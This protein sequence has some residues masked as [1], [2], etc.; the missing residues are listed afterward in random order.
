MFSRIKMWIFIVS[1]GIIEKVL[2]SFALSLFIPAFSSSSIEGREAGRSGKA[3][4][5]SSVSL[6]LISL[7]KVVDNDKAA[8]ETVPYGHLNKLICCLCLSLQI[9]PA[10][11][12]PGHFG[13]G[14]GMVQEQD[15][16]ACFA[17]ASYCPLQLHY[18]MVKWH[19]DISI[20]F[21]SSFSPM[22]SFY[23]KAIYPFNRFLKRWD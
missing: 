9:Y 8:L 1:Y 13:T 17:L 18:G 3:G 11:C 6:S 23:M 22:K 19:F 14:H 5:A 2:L 20:C 7:V 15:T 12:L 21:F 4:S 10:T 16:L